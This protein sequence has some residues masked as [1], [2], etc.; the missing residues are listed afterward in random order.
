[1]HEQTAPLCAVSLFRGQQDPGMW[2]GWLARLFNFKRGHST[3]QRASSSLGT[4]GKRSCKRAACP[5]VA[6]QL[7]PRPNR[8]ERRGAAGQ[9]A[10]KVALRKSRN[11]VTHGSPQGDMPDAAQRARRGVR[12]GCRWQAQQKAVPPWLSAPQPQCLLIRFGTHASDWVGMLWQP[13]QCR[14]QNSGQTPSPH[15]PHTAALR[16]FPMAPAWW[17]GRADDRCSGVRMH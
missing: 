12:H 13:V 7:P 16:S 17:R 9:T 14:T 5:T 6:P 2:S 4:P 8:A 15:A 3:W 10:C 11:G 1:M